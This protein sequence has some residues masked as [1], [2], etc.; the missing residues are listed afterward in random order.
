MGMLLAR[1]TGASCVLCQLVTRLVVTGGGLDHSIMAVL[2]MNA[3]PMHD[4]QV[5]PSHQECKRLMPLGRI[6]LS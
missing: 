5:M 6:P 4:M 1:G 3:W 2:D